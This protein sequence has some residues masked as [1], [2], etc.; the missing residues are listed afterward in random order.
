MRGSSGR[1]TTLSPQR[2]SC[3]HM[4]VILTWRG[5]KHYAWLRTLQFHHKC[6]HIRRLQ[7]TVDSSRHCSAANGI[8]V[9]QSC[10][11]RSHL[12][13]PEP[14]CQHDGRPLPLLQPL[15]LCKPV[16]RGP[17]G[18]SGSAASR[19]PLQCVCCCCPS[20]PACSKTCQPWQPHLRQ[21][22]P[23]ARQCACPLD[24][25]WTGCW[26]PGRCHR[27][28]VRLLQQVLGGESASNAEVH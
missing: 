12:H 1:M 17:T 9:Q 4:C 10:L 22:E 19:P 15:P 18:P 16:Q 2:S 20:G 14:P 23:Q 3:V 8:P 5:C 13:P 11:T 21:Q 28:A 6:S 26:W 7:P 24:R 25:G 27:A